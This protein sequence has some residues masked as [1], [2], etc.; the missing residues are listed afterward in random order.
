M[1]MMQRYY[2]SD[3]YNA[4]SA[5]YNKAK[6]KILDLEIDTKAFDAL[7][8]ENVILKA[9]L[10]EAQEEIEELENELI[11]LYGDWTSKNFDELL[12]SAR[13]NTLY[14]AEGQAVISK[15]DDWFYEDHWDELYEELNDD[16]E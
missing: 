7:K 15:D 6:A 4:L 10:L 2:S 12:E 3:E 8:K 13:K 5:K 14:N 9:Q 11:L 1:A 16:A